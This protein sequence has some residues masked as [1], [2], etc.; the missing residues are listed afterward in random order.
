VPSDSDISHDLCEALRQVLHDARLS[1]G[2]SLGEVAARAGLNRQAVTFIEKGERR[3]T[4]DTFV[5]L[6]F[7]LGM[8]PSEA[9]LRAEASLPSQRIKLLPACP[10][11]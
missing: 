9:W 3:P 8:R 1:A 7:A 2:L 4:A 5:R 10:A 11:R 6:A